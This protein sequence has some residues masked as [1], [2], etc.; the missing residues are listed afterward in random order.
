[1]LHDP[2]AVDEGYVPWL[3]VV[4][5]QRVLDHGLRRA[6][7]TKICQAHGRSEIRGFGRTARRIWP[8]VPPGGLGALTTALARCVR[9][10]VL[11]TAEWL[12]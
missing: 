4:L 12:P 7:A 9:G 5:D 11:K 10:R 1:M 2:H 6:T 8:N 3:V